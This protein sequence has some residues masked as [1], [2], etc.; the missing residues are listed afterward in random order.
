MVFSNI[1]SV[2]M[3]CTGGGA[4]ER[5]AGGRP[6]RALTLTLQAAAAAPHIAVQTLPTGVGSTRALGCICALPHRRQM[7]A[8]RGR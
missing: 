5:A 7:Q 4:Q 1:M 8:V 6:V 2:C 3:N